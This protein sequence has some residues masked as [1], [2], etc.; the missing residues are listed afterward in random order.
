V[1]RVPGVPR[2]AEDLGEVAAPGDDV[3]RRELA[4]VQAGDAQ[5]FEDRD[6]RRGPRN[7]PVA[8]EEGGVALGEI[9]GYRRV[10]VPLES[11]AVVDVRNLPR[12]T[13][14]GELDG[15]LRTAA[16]DGSVWDGWKRREPGWGADLTK[17]GAISP[18][19]PVSSAVWAGFRGKGRA[20][21]RYGAAR[22]TCPSGGGSSRTDSGASHRSSDMAPL[23]WRPEFFWESV[24]PKPSQ[25]F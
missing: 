12:L 15:F 17:R 11:R 19:R 23:Q 21:T 25:N 6:E 5:G 3:R 18:S 24:D 9:E 14:R 4:L 2:G 10:D 7:V 8:I 13:E 22:G 20:L 1:P 16:M